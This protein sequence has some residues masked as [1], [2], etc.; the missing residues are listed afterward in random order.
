MTLKSANALYSSIQFVFFFCRALIF[1]FASAFLLGKGFTNTQIGLVLFAGYFLSVV[2]MQLVASWE[3]KMQI[4][5]CKLCVG[6]AVMMNLIALVLFFFP[7]NKILL[8]ALMAIIVACAACLSSYVNIVYR[9]YYNGGLKINFSAA[10]G[11]GS[12]S[13]A[14]S[15]L[16]AGL[17][18]AQVATDLMP[19][20]YLIP[21]FIL[22]ILLM[23]FDAPN[24]EEKD[25]QAEILQNQEKLIKEYPHFLLF[26]LAVCLLYL[27]YLFVSLYLLQIMQNI[28]GDVNNVG[29]ALFLEGM[30][31]FP[32]M[33]LYRTISK[34]MGNRKLMSIACWFLCIK[35]LII[36]FAPNPYIIYLAQILQFMSFAM[37]LPSSEKHIAHVVPK[38]KYVRAQA[39]LATAT[40]VSYMIVS[41]A[42]G[43][44]LDKVGVF[45]TLLVMDWLALVGCLVMDIS[46]QMSYKKVPKTVREA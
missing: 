6:L 37:Y 2:I 15:A 3:K 39:L 38:T 26:L 45:N 14:I 42:G 13:S 18:F 23:F 20:L 31:E 16:V 27:P 28:G 19:A 33:L 5:I 22:A 8:S 9:G 46:V 36:T 40:T 24:V 30:I 21:T 43:L 1:S 12:A 34:K 25:K 41:F 32:A 10:R 44:L 4:N 11:V 7:P 35:L 29:T 17:I